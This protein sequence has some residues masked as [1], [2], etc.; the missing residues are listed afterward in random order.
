MFGKTDLK[1]KNQN[2]DLKNFEFLLP[3]RIL[4]IDFILFSYMYN[5]AM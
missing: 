1:K 4:N 2:S 5:Q 3:Q